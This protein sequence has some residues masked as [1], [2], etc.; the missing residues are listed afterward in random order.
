MSKRP[1]E[2]EAS[3][4]PEDKKPKNN[5][6][7]PLRKPLFSCLAGVEHKLTYSLLIAR[8][9]SELYRWIHYYWHLGFSDKEIASHVLD[10]FDREKFGIR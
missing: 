3:A 2:D 5:Q 6:H 1:Q 4:E 9:A 7:L 10:H 8:P